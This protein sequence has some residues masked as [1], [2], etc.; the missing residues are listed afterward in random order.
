MTDT[1]PSERTRVKRYHWL[2]KYDKETIHAIVDASPHAHV[3]YVHEG[4]PLVTPTLVWRD[5]ERLYW[6]GSRVARMIQATSGQEVCLCVSIIDG[7]VLA[8][9]AYNYNIN[10]RSV[11]VFGVARPVTDPEEKRLQLQRFVDGLIPGQWDRL[12]PMTEQEL[13][14]TALVVLDLG[15]ASAKVRT[16]PPEDDEADYALPI[17]AGVIPV[18]TRIDAPVPDPRNHPDAQMPEDVLKFKLG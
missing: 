7:L 3:G 11:M 17:W 13:A 15:E 6:H 18:G 9:S 2:A 16:G 14:V 10:H 8:R 5:G 4:R 1:P 12:R